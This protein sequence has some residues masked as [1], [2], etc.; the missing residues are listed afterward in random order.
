MIGEQ[1]GWEGRDER[2]GE[3]VRKK[4]RERQCDR[5]SEDERVQK[6]QCYFYHGFDW[7]P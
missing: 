7:N 1:T 6:Y 4:E 3:Q 2:N 5:N